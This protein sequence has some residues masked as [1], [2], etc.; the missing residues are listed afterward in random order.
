MIRR[1]GQITALAVCA[2]ALLLAL[3]LVVRA[4]TN[5]LALL[6]LVLGEK[7]FLLAALALAGLL[8]A[9]WSTRA[10]SRRLWLRALAVAFTVPTLLLAA[11]PVQGA[12]RLAAQRGVKL[13][14]WRYLTAPIDTAAARP[15]GSASFAAVDGARLMLDFYAPAGVDLAGEPAPAVIVVH[16]GGWSKGDKGETARANRWL[17]NRGFAVFDIQYR[18][19]PQP[20]WRTATGDVKCA[21]GWVKERAQAATRIAIDPERVALLGRSA[22]GHLALLAAYTADDPALPPSCPV[23][24]PRVS[25]VAAYYAPTDLEWGYRQP[26]NPRV[27]D[28]SQKLRDFLGGDPASVPD[29]YRAAGIVNRVTAAAP[30]TLLVHGGRDQFVSPLHVYRL[31]PFL[32][33]ARI[34]HDVLIVAHGQHGFDH[35]FGGLGAQITEVTL[36][37]FLQQGMS[38]LAGAGPS[39]GRIVSGHGSQDRETRTRDTLYMLAR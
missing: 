33:K 1:A 13:N 16:G 6:A 2:L 8:S 11:W 29:A 4:P 10:S 15:D 5:L 38:R 18:L 26:A 34:E 24:D 35:I 21:V 28:T 32:Q 39:R 25:A 17:A 3:L 7:S 30:R 20:N 14:L 31:Q 22:G 23:R 12:F 9:W 19:A 36:L 37:R 27:Y